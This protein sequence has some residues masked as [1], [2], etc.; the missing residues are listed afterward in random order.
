MLLFMC[1]WAFL[2]PPTDGA[3]YLIVAKD[4]PEQN[5][6]FFSVLQTLK[7]EGYSIFFAVPDDIPLEQVQLQLPPRTASL[8]WR[9]TM[10]FDGKNPIEELDSDFECDEDCEE[11]SSQPAEKRQKITDA[12][13]LGLK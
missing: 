9:W 4:I 6:E 1:E 7:K 2:N 8:V 3:N 13:S 10:L 11:G 5:T 12:A